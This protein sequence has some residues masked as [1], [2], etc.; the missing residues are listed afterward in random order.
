MCKIIYDLHI[1]QKLSV[2]LLDGFPFDILKFRKFGDRQ[3]DVISDM[4]NGPPFR[5]FTTN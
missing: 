4:E 1:V 5:N 3:T 2:S